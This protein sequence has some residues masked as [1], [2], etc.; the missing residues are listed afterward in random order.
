MCGEC[1]VTGAAW[2]RVW[3][4]LLWNTPRT[5]CVAERKDIG[6]HSVL[7]GSPIFLSTEHIVSYFYSTN[8]LGRVWQTVISRREEI[9]NIYKR[10]SVLF[11]FLGGEHT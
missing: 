3:E 2:Q 4:S 9:K 10:Q 6:S 7:V 11:I 1:G 5:F 8:T